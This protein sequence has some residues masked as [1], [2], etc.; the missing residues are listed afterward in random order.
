MVNKTTKKWIMWGGPVI[1]VIILLG[2]FFYEPVFGQDPYN[3]TYTEG[4]FAAGD[5]ARGFFAAG[6]FA[7]GVV[8]AGTFSVGIVSVGLFSI[9][10][11]SMGLF[12]IGFYSVGIFLIAKHKDTIL[13]KE[14]EKEEDI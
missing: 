5:Y 7:V 9:G 6:R 3:V 14:R 11:F 12:S 4:F 10:I 8:A 13:G 2:T 1:F